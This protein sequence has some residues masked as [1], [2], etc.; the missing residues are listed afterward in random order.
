M[1]N[2]WRG[3]D[4][5]LFCWKARRKGL[6]HER[7]VGTNTRRVMVAFQ[8]NIYANIIGSTLIGIFICKGVDTFGKS[9]YFKTISLGSVPIHVLADQYT[10]FLTLFNSSSLNFSLLRSAEC[11]LVY[12][13]E[14]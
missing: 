4:C 2:E 11:S 3:L 7:S 1:F 14:N 5:A 10:T 6:E 8:V 12:L 13:K 9:M